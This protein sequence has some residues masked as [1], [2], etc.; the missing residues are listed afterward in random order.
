MANFELLESLKIGFTYNMSDKKFIMNSKNTYFM[1]YL[2]LQVV[3]PR[4]LVNSCWICLK[5]PSLTPN[6]RVWI[7]IT[8]SLNT[9]KLTVPPRWGGERTEP[10][11]VSTPS[12]PPHATL[13]CVWLRKKKLLP[14]FHL[15]PKRKRFLKRNSRGKSCK[16]TVVKEELC[17]FPRCWTK[18][19]TKYM[20]WWNFYFAEYLLSFLIWGGKY[21]WDLVPYSV[22]RKLQDA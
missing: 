6:T 17:N 2:F 18:N 10:T 19:F 7:P 3:G 12:C 22:E 16:W 8:W 15:N 14:R 21:L 5:M 20:S 4:S 1:L 11:V 13:K 9:S